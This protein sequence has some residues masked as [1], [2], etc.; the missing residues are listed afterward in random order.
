M[1]ELLLELIKAYEQD[2]KEILTYI[3]TFEGIYKNRKHKPENKE[4]AKQILVRLYE[5]KDY[6]AKRVKFYR[7][8]YQKPQVGE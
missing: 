6:Y 8:I 4:L 1:N 5:E 2:F 3:K 7:K